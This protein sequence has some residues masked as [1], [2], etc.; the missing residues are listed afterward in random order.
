MEKTFVMAAGNMIRQLAPV[1]A[2]IVEKLIGHI[3]T[4]AKLAAQ[5]R[6]IDAERITNH[7]PRTYQQWLEHLQQRILAVAPALTPEERLLVHPSTLN[8]VHNGKHCG[9]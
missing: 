8:H 2:A 3:L 9:L 6:A 7:E 5:R 1:G 4:T